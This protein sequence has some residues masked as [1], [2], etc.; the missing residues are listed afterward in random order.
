MARRDVTQFFDDLDNSPINE[1]DLEV[2]RFGVNGK[3]Y[4]LDL[5]HANAEKFHAAL[6]PYI[7]AAR[8]A[9]ATTPKRTDPRE[10]REWAKKQGIEV[11]KRGKIPSEIIDAYNKVH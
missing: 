2:V 3:N 4:I 6:A 11:A 7:E 10:V 9:Q 5:S 1:E 8:P